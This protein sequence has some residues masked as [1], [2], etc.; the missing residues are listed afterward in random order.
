MNDMMVFTVYEVSLHIR[1]VLETS[2][3]PLY[4]SGEISNF[5]HHSS[6]HMYFN[7]KDPNATLRCTFFKGANYSLKFKPEDGMQVICFGKITLYE[8]GGTYNLN[9]SSMQ[10]SGQGDLARQFELLKQK[11]DA[12]GL[13]DSSH[14]KALP[15]YPERIGIVSSPTGAAIQDI[16]NI[17]R[18]RFPVKVFLYP[19]VVQGNEA[20]PQL[21]DGLQFFNTEMPVD[22]IIITR[23]GGSQEDLWAFNDE[24]LARAIFASRIPVISAVGHEIDFSI[25]DFVADHRAPTPSAAAELAVPD[26]TELLAYLEVLSKRIDLIFK[27]DLQRKAEVLRSAE[28]IHRSMHPQDKIDRKA[29]QLDMVSLVFKDTVKIL[30]SKAGEL[31]VVEQKFLNAARYS[32]QTSFL[33]F[34]SRLDRSESLMHQGMEQTIIRRR[35][36]LSLL[37]MRLQVNSPQLIMAKGYGILRKGENL[38]RS[39]H[40]AT[41]G[42]VLEAC[43][44]DGKLNV[45]VRKITRNDTVEGSN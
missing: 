10:L 39:V 22:L 30:K 20:P 34:T 24:K 14:K 12:E 17:L 13:F 42:E 15:K 44:V 26:K 41:E 25:S 23:G 40:D 32:L 33:R 31:N 7:L 37:D 29:Q 36:K 18:R 9:V 35:E 3:E 4:I 8:K 19:A 28:L 38:I 1:Q 27:R 45:E 6:G 16:M 11:L 5:T 2:L 21:I 43:L